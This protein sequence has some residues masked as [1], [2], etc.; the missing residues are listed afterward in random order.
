MLMEVHVGSHIDKW[1]CWLLYQIQTSR[2]R[3]ALW[4]SMQCRAQRENICCLL[5][6]TKDPSR[7]HISS[8]F[9][10]HHFSKMPLNRGQ[11]HALFPPHLYPHFCVVSLICQTTN[12][13]RG[14]CS[15][16][17]L[18]RRAWVSGHECTPSLGKYDIQT[19]GRKRCFSIP[20]AQE[21]L[22]EAHEPSLV[23]VRWQ[24]AVWR[25]KTLT[26]P[27]SSSLK[28]YL[29]A[30]LKKSQKKYDSFAGHRQ[31]LSHGEAV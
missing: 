11:V 26:G 13:F 18:K 14:E 6:W 27:I 1:H 24:Q 8:S 16:V 22:L 23:S 15:T 25:T 21:K 4:N 10:R 28:I 5:K 31:G 17:I 7:C 3:E 30:D 9:L 12:F 29:H 19:R 2:R 20:A